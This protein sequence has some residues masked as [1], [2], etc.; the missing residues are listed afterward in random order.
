[1]KTVAIIPAFN[2]EKTLGG[3]ISDLK[4]YVNQIIVIDDGSTDKTNQ[5]AR[6]KNIKI[7]RH[8]I[9]RG[10]GG[11]L[12]TGIEAALQNGAD[13]II[14]ID[15]DGQHD[16]SEIPKLIKPII[17][18]KADAVIGSRFLTRQPMP[19]FRRV[20][21]I[22]FNFVTFFLFGAKTTDS[23]SGMRA[24]SKKGAQSLEIHS[25]GMEVSS[26]ILKEIKIK[27]IRMKEVPI[28]SIYTDYSLS[29]GQ[30]LLPGIKTLIKILWSLFNF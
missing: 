2:E 24:F 5:I 20:G 27:K 17:E 1:M 30:G 21:N 29:K 10:L 19:L 25:N 3:V 22:F 13:I 16:P 14:T 8:L 12:K 6:S 9:N 11:V 4:K 7:Y 18:Q 23:Q 26:E 28:K 15:A